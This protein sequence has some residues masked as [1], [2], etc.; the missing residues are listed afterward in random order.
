VVEA[1]GSRALSADQRALEQVA[2]WGVQRL[3]VF[4]PAWEPPLLELL[5]FLTEVRRRVGQAV[6]IVL[7]PVPE[8]ARDV[9]DVEHDT[10]VQAI[11]RLR[12]PQLYVETGAA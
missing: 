6:S 10:W 2:A 12:D 1:G 4:T 9:T 3:I 8:E 5:D 11:G 7:T